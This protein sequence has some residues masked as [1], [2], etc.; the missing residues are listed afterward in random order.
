MYIEL[1][2]G[3][4][5]YYYLLM[6]L[7]SMLNVLL[8]YILLT[9]I[10]MMEE[11][12]FYDL[13]ESVYTVYTQFGTLL[14]ASIIMMQFYQDYKEK[15][16]IFY[17]VLNRNAIS[18]FISK[19]SAVIL[20]TILGTMVSSFMICVPYGEIKWL[21]VIFLKTEA[22]MLYYSLIMAVIGFLFENFLVGFFLNF[23]I[24]IIGIVVSDLS[25]CFQ[26]CA[27]YDASGNDYEVFVSFLDDKLTITDFVSVI[28]SDYI[29]DICVFA[30][31]LAIVFLFRKR[32][33][34]NG[35]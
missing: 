2:R 22:V 16:I 15:N 20:G 35:I 11:V 21:P 26:S 14:F 1:K 7:I 5:N 24:W 10:D 29:F 34:K 8:G 17:K 33:V 23:F 18:Y 27:F 4:R 30:V 9:T 3:V 32:W 12:T 28:G 6:I 31:C 19:I 25:T 13:W